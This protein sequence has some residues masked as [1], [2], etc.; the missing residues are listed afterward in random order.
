M[1]VDIHRPTALSFGVWVDKIS[2]NSLRLFWIRLTLFFLISFWT[3][4]HF[5][6]REKL[7]ILD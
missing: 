6:R 7:M 3:M 2:L 4:V 5:G 1:F